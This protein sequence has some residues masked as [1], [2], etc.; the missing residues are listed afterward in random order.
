M[1][2]A[3]EQKYDGQRASIGRIVV[4]RTEESGLAAGIVDGI[5]YDGENG[6]VVW[7]AEAGEIG[8]V[9]ALAFHP[10]QSAEDIEAMPVGTWTWPVRA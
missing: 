7:I 9:E 10:T 5:G 2:Y 8:C 4:I 6:E 1:K 3:S